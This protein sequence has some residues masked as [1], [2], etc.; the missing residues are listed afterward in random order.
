MIAFVAA[1]AT[2]L[3]PPRLGCVSEGLAPLFRA[4]IAPTRGA[5]ANGL[6]LYWRRREFA[7]REIEHLQREIEQDL[8]RQSTLSH[9]APKRHGSSD[10]ENRRQLRRDVHCC[11]GACF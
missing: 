11:L 6:S 9:D 5:E 10:A 8:W 7:A 1:R 4:D 2:V 3:G